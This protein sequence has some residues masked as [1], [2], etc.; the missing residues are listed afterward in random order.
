VRINYKITLNFVLDS[1]A[2][3]VQIPMDVIRTLIRTG[4][5]SEEDFLESK[6]YIQ[7]DGS[8]VTN[9]RLLIKRLQV[10][11]E[12]LLNVTTSIS[13]NDGALLLGQN[14]LERFSG[15]SIDNDKQ[16]LVLGDQRGDQQ[17]E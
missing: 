6:D 14:F 5:I 9:E 17:N 7:V 13:K 12:V 15:W 4:T 3:D 2:G 8:T 11:D 10:G 16:A 1:G